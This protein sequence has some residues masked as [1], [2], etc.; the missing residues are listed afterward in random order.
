MCVIFRNCLSHARSY[1]RVCLCTYIQGTLY[2]SIIIFLHTGTNSRGLAR[3][4]SAASIG[5]SR[6]GHSRNLWA[7]EEKLS[8]EVRVPTLRTSDST[9]IIVKPH[10]LGVQHVWYI[11]SHINE[12][13][14]NHIRSNVGLAKTRP[15][16]YSTKQGLTFVTSTSLE[17]LTHSCSTLHDSLTLTLPHFHVAINISL[18]PYLEP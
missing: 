5:T 9:N 15:F 16:D 2:S 6:S 14:M 8:Y 13:S 3:R 10:V 7:K 1:T 18:S 4:S 11:L 12:T 17:S